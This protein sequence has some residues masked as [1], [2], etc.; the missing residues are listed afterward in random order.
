M[1]NQITIDR[2]DLQQLL[3]QAMT[4]AIVEVLKIQRIQPAR[5][6]EECYTKEDIARIFDVSPDTVNTWVELQRIPYVKPGAR[7]ANKTRSKSP[8]RFYPPQIRDWIQRMSVPDM[9]K[10]QVL[11]ALGARR[12]DVSR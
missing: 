7:E 9:G 12:K 3:A 10:L 4:Q 6:L 8:V 1:S 11:E 5:D 2:D